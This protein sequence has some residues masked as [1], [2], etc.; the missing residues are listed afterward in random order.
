MKA[1]KSQIE[2]A[3]Y[4]AFLKTINQ[5]GLQ[6]FKKSTLFGR[7]DIVNAKQAD[8]QKAA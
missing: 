8:D 2:T 6:Q 7:N 4:H 3:L 1:S 5:I